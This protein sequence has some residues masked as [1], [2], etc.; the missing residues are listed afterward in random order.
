MDGRPHGIQ[1]TPTGGGPK[2]LRTLCWQGTHQCWRQQ[3]VVETLVLNRMPSLT[4][5]ASGLDVQ[6]QR[7][8]VQGQWLLINS[9]SRVESLALS[10]GQGCE[11]SHLLLGEQHASLFL[12]DKRHCF[13]P[14][15]WEPSEATATTRSS[16]AK[17][18]K[19]QK[20]LQILWA[21]IWQ[22]LIMRMKIFL[23]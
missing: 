8:A 16:L 12:L 14:C 19:E 2:Y 4:E 5:L 15:P 17:A 13:T 11:S 9:L 20:A 22:Q 18:G 6:P 23:F 21:E 1:M 7:I 3:W 10:L